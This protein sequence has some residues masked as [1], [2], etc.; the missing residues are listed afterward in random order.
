MDNATFGRML[1]RPVPNLAPRENHDPNY[2]AG[3]DIGG[4][5]LIRYTS[6]PAAQGS[7]TPPAPTRPARQT[8]AMSIRPFGQTIAQRFAGGHVEIAHRPTNMPGG[9][10]ELGDMAAAYQPATTN[11]PPTS[12]PWDIK[13]R[14]GG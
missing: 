6:D 8:L 11:R 9:S 4:Q 7:G 10:A 14:I 5:Q 13:S 2:A 3:H 1:A 12:C